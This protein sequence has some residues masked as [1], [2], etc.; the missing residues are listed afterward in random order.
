[1]TAA[2]V[3]LAAV[4]AAVV[5]GLVWVRRRYVVVHVSGRSMEPTLTSGQRVFARRARLDGVRGGDVVVLAPPPGS[6]GGDG[7]LVKRVF[8]LPGDPM[9]RARVP[10][11]RA[12]P[13]ERVPAGSLVVLGD[14]PALSIDSRQLGLFPAERLVG[15][16]VRRTSPPPV[17]PGVQS[18]PAPT[19]GPAPTDGP[20]DGPA[21]TDGPNDGPASNDGPLAPGGPPGD[22]GRAS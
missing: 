22:A 1:M 14:N 18:R 17:P 20:T 15:V 8:A 16:L 9:P 12:V 19:E 4:A 10:K 7:L 3:A 11:L 13:G 5:A 6:P 21:P 2:L